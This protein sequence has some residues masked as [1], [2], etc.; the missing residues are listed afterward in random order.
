MLYSNIFQ[1]YANILHQP[2]PKH[3]YK[4]LYAIA[5]CKVLFRKE[6]EVRVFW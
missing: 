6:E 5:R 4:F 2:E 1:Q 3:Q